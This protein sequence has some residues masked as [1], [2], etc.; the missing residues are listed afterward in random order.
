MIALLQPIRQNVAINMQGIADED[1]PGFY[2]HLLPRLLELR[3]QVGRPHWIVIDQAHQLLPAQPI[4]PPASLSQYPKGMLFVT[5]H[6][7]RLPPRSSGRSI[8]SWPRATHMSK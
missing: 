8:W 2:E 4:V 7:D 1:R 5:S 6:P 3:N